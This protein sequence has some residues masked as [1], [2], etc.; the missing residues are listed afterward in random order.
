ML[1]PV[2]EKVKKGEAL[3][4]VESMKMEIE[5]KAPCDGQIK[6]YLIDQG[7]GITSGQHLAYIQQDLSSSLINL[8]FI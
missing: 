8:L 4:I 1:K 2:G 6:K 5:I 7:D 3:I